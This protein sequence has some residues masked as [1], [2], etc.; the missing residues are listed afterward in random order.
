MNSH[1][2]EF[3]KTMVIYFRDFGMKMGIDF[4]SSAVLSYPKFSQLP[5][6]S[7]LCLIAAHTYQNIS[8]RYINRIQATFTLYQVTF[9]SD[10]KLIQIILPFTLGEVIR[11]NSIPAIWYFV[12]TQKRFSSLPV[13]VENCTSI[14]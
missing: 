11:Q 6:P 7:G 5:A 4:A 9:E 3:G 1:F 2:R 13:E 12:P 14:S 8:I 10:T